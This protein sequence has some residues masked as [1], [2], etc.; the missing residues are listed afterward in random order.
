MISKPYGDEFYSLRREHMAISPIRPR[1][2]M[3]IVPAPGRSAR[4]RLWEVRPEFLCPVIG[5]CTT[6]TEQKEILRRAGFSSAGCRPDAVH[7]FLVKQARSA[8]PVSQRL[9]KRLNQK[10]RKEMARFGNLEAAAFLAAWQENL[11]HGNIE[12]LFWIAVSR[13]DLAEADL[14][15]IYGDVHM[16]SFGHIKQGLQEK[17]TL[18]RLEAK[19]RELEQKLAT[20]VSR[21]R[22]HAKEKQALER[23]LIKLQRRNQILEKQGHRPD[24]LTNRQ[25][26]KGKTACPAEL[27][28]LRAEVEVLRRQVKESADQAHSWQARYQQLAEKMARQQALADR[29]RQEMAPPSPPRCE[30]CTEQ[31]PDFDLCARRILLVGGITKIEPFYRELVEDRGGHFEYHD[32]YM[33]QGQKKLEVLVKRA[34]AVLCPLACNSHAA[35]RCLRKLCRKYRKP[36]YPLPGASLE[37]VSQALMKIGGQ[38]NNSSHR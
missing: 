7:A 20:E 12:G 15:Q 31:C 36:F 37:S 10:F 8:N 4:L 19:T 29:L 25:E 18:A 6:L 35:C 1:P 17:R 16:L 32:G 3:G 26:S 34:D 22:A 5:L 11:R 38:G 27:Q 21:R 9:E 28:A 24:E 23:D 30:Q 13:G 14:D 33:Q 2:E